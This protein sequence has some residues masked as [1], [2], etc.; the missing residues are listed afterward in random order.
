MNY[1]PLVGGLGILA[2]L[3]PACQSAPAAGLEEIASAYSKK[4]TEDLA[5]DLYWKVSRLGRPYLTDSGDI[6]V[7]AMN[8]KL[9]IEVWRLDNHNNS[10]CGRF[11]QAKIYLGMGELEEYSSEYSA[12]VCSDLYP[13]ADFDSKEQSR[14]KKEYRLLLI[15]IL[16]DIGDIKFG[17]TY[18]AQVPFQVLPTGL[19]ATL[20]LKEI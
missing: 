6:A 15:E 14:L 20:D 12:D 16:E 8:N 9:I 11:A 4:G 5:E 1:Y 10:I 13:V 19:F 17:P 3:T 2:L 7:Y 18:K